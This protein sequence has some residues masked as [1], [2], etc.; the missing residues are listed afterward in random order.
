MP[1]LNI[2]FHAMP[3]E[4]LAFAIESAESSGLNMVIAQLFPDFKIFAVERDDFCRLNSVSIVINSIF[5]IQDIPRISDD[6][7]SFLRNNANMLTLSIGK[8]DAEGLRE[9]ILSGQTEDTSIFKKWNIV[10]SKLKKITIA[11]VWIVNPNNNCKNYYKNHRY[12]VEA[13]NRYRN[14][15]K[16][17]PGNG[18]N[19]F[20]LETNNN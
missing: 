6:Y 19:Y 12:T 7:M 13:R 11:G 9:S 17:M 20:L 16:M 15:L 18:W 10:S 2:Q 14:G 3:Y 1:R 4:V 5:F 8:V